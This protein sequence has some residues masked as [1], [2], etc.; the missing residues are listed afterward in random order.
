MKKIL[1]L[2]WLV[3]SMAWAQWPHQHIS[4]ATFAQSVDNRTPI[5]LITEA[6]NRL[7]KVYFFTNI[8]HLTG[9]KITH[10]WLYQDTVKAEVS[11]DIKGP[12]WRVWSSKNLWH[13][14]TGTWRVD[15]L[16]SRG[17]KLLSKTF[18]YKKAR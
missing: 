12:R 2:L 7:S 5:N 16:N 15:V 4:Q 14:W 8:R 11:F 1:V 9:E 10:R 6:D 3:S 13:K 18:E 17:E